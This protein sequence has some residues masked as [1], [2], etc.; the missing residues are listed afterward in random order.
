VPP[1][2]AELAAK[3]P[4]LEIL[5]LIGRG[6]MGAVY[7]ARQRQ[8]DRVVALKILPPG[9][10]GDSAFAER[11]AREA[12]A[13]AKLNHPGIVTLYEFGQVGSGTGVS[14]VSIEGNANQQHT[15]KMP[16]PLFYF[17]ME[18][19]DGV[20]LRQLLT[21]GRI[22]P[23]EALAIV[24]QIC[25]ALQFAHD[26]GIIHR[27]IKPENI[28]LDRRGRVKVADFGLAKLIGTETGRAG[29]PLPDDGAHGVTRPTDALTESGKIMGT[30]NYM[31]PEQIQAPGEVDHRADIYALGVVF[32][33]MLTGE[34]PGKTIAPPSSKVRIDVRL[35]EIVLRALQKNPELRYQ[36][37]SEV[38]TCVET[39]AATPPGSSGREEAQTESGKRK[40]ESGKSGESLVI[41]AATNQ[42]AR[43]S[44]TAIAGASL[45]VLALVFWGGAWFVDGLSEAGLTDVISN[46]T[47]YEL[48]SK[49]LAAVGTLCLL[50][51]P[52]LGWIAVAQIRRSAGKLHGLGLAVFDGLLFPLLALDFVFLTL[53]H[54]LAM[55]LFS[56]VGGGQFT[57][58]DTVANQQAPFLV[59]TCVRLAA[60]IALVL[61]FFIIRRV[62]RAVNNDGVG[63]PPVE[64][65]RKKSTGKMIAIGCGVI[66]AA[67]ILL[68]V[69]VHSMHNSALRAASLTSAD[70]HWQVFE[71]DSALVDRLL[72]TGQRQHGVQSTA[73]AYSKYSDYGGSKMVNNGT[74]SFKV[75]ISKGPEIDSWVANLS[76]ETLNALLDGVGNK[77]NIL[78]NGTQT[79]SG[80]WWP[81]GMPTIWTYSQRDGVFYRGGNGAIYLAIRQLD[82]QNN[83]RIEG[84]IH[85]QT[86]LNEIVGITSR[87]LYEGKTPQNGA[88]A[89]LVPFFRQ[90][91]SEHYLVVVYEIGNS[92]ASAT[93][94]AATQHLSFDSFVERVRQELSRA[95]IRFDKL[96]IS[97]V[98]DDSF[99]V[100]F[101]GLEVHGVANGKDAWLPIQTIGFG[102]EL[103]AQRGRF[104]GKWNFTGSGQLAVVRFTVA[105]LDLEELLKT[106]LTEAMP[107]AVQNLSF[108]PVIERVLGYGESDSMVFLDLDTGKASQLK[109]LFPENAVP[110]E[111][112]IY[113]KARAVGI[114]LFGNTDPE[115]RS[116][117]GLDMVAFP[118]SAT[119]WDNENARIGK[120]PGD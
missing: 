1:D 72:P 68:I 45:V 51:S 78:A 15:G 3:F 5:E 47:A 10:G 90:D 114:D 99:F 44:R 105:G 113:Q 52:L 106:N 95:S 93:L 34:L 14:P 56:A 103:N 74:N 101:S 85:H 112:E 73:K 36:Q 70:F 35:D 20:N 92:S 81:N 54:L 27:D 22:S 8:L 6:G 110:S 116:L 89:F 98:N 67:A 39:I 60:L 23:R 46:M 61:D 18:F 13:L 33:Q 2:I 37:V 88:L 4:Q 38:K 65:S 49:A 58:D 29:S 69:A 97:A 63:V 79:V 25:D 118:V 107:A 83:I 75:T 17:L 77:T 91:S 76:P 94:P 30:P 42:E 12:K 16:V 71:A 120:R 62:W 115:I 119:E 59:P 7:K 102:D 40:A 32:Y 117:V 26:Q 82:G 100:S 21:T 64:P 53:G 19:V 84:E 86:D 11:F 80:V 48:A 96:H 109:D 41:S 50:I 24:P 57:M 66:L 55:I 111:E 108:S 28:L 104:D 31:S 87:F 43:F 9:I